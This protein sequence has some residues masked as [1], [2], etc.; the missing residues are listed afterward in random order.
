MRM[1]LPYPLLSVGLFGVSI[2]IS[3]ALSPP[4]LGLALLVAFAIPQSMRALGVAPV[5]VRAP[6]AILKLTGLVV[7]D[8]L[9]SNW[10][11]AQILLGRRHGERV[12]GFIQIPLDLRDRYG[13]AVLAIILTSTPGTLWVEYQRVGGRLLLHVLDLVDEEQWIRLVKDRYEG[14]LMEIF[15]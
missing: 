3:G 14:L 7:G 2:L 12:S 9:R 8:V 1:L 15:E 10:A 13:L 5:R 11:V 6:L 4:S